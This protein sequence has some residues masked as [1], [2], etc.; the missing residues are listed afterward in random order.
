M[1]EIEIGG[2]KYDID[3][4]G[5]LQ[6]LDKWKKEFAES[7]AKS[8]GIEGSLTEDHWKIIHYIRGYYEKFGTAPMIRKMCKETGF[9][10]K[11]V[12]KLFPTGPAKGAC[13]IAGLSKPTGCV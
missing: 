5:F 11:T 13:K 2:E 4:D 9:D 12:Y 8:E 7:V 3:E 10:L 6:N 1:A